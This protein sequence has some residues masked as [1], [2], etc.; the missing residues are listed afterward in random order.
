M[1]PT[2]NTRMETPRYLE[3]WID[4]MG[5]GLSKGPEEIISCSTSAGGGVRRTVNKIVEEP[6]FAWWAKHAVLRKCDC[7]IKE[8]KSR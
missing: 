8:V 4:L 6:A 2:D 3:G 1:A 7:I 5:A